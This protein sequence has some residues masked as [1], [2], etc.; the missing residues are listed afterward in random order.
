M[1]SENMIYADV[2]GNIGWIA[3]GFMPRRSWSGLLPVPG[4]PGL[5]PPPTT[6]RRAL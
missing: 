4:R 6:R 5:E 2:D 1:P 3:A